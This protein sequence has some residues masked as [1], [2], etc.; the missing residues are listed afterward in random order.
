MHLELEPRCPIDFRSLLKID[1]SVSD[2]VLVDG[3]AS[4]PAVKV[5]PPIRAPP[6]VNG[7]NRIIAAPLLKGQSAITSEPL[8]DHSSSVNHQPQENHESSVTEEP[9]TQDAPSANDETTNHGATPVDGEVSANGEAVTKGEQ[10]SVVRNTTSQPSTIAAVNPQASSNPAAS[11]LP[12]IATADSEPKSGAEA[13]GRF[14]IEPGL[15]EAARAWLKD[16][17]SRPEKPG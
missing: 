17:R 11:E 2:Q 14:A 8:V 3:Q 13:G 7:T 15:K 9:L 4:Q 16:Q 10:E 12:N 1:R 5:L 6:P